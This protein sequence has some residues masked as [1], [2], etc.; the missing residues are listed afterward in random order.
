[1]FS[2]LY[3][4]RLSIRRTQHGCGQFLRL[5]LVGALLIGLAFGLI[6]GKRLFNYQVPL[7]F[8]ATGELSQGGNIWRHDPIIHSASERFTQVDLYPTLSR[9]SNLREDGSFN[10]T[11]LDWPDGFDVRSIPPANY[12]LGIWLTKLLLIATSSPGLI[13]NVLFIF[14]VISLYLLSLA[15]MMRLRFRS[16]YAVVGS[17]AIALNPSLFGKEPFINNYWHGILL[18]I[19]AIFLMFQNKTVSVRL[20]AI[21]GAITSVSGLY[22]SVMSP[23]LLVLAIIFLPRSI[24]TPKVR[25]LAIVVYLTPILIAMVVALGPTAIYWRQIG[26]TTVS[27]AQASVESWPARITDAL[28]VPNYSIFGNFLTRSSFVEANYGEGV[29]AYGPYGFLALLVGLYFSVGL[30]LKDRKNKAESEPMAAPASFLATLHFVPLTGGLYALFTP[31]MPDIIKSWE[32]FQV[33][34]A[35]VSVFFLGIWYN[36]YVSHLTRINRWIFQVVAVGSLLFGVIASLPIGKFGDPNGARNRW[37]SDHDFYTRIE[38]VSTNQNIL[39]L[40]VMSGFEGGPWGVIP[41]YSDLIGSI[42]TSK[43]RFSG[44]L[45]PRNAELANQNFNMKSDFNQV[46]REMREEGFNALVIDNRESNL[47]FRRNIVVSGLCEQFFLSENSQFSY[48]YL[49]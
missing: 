32:R 24:S 27:R 15:L 4:S 30:F 29:Y 10:S 46:V 34:L 14:A 17:L 44:G 18:T 43:V 8:S 35:I 2:P 40:P 39:I 7:G 49:P 1:V 37:A 3:R 6:Y 48:C 36:T 42:H 9:I 22:A 16:V 12:Y 33:P 5:G 20:L 25:V 45:V 28:S 47:S 21:A 23:I 38:S 11:R 19:G 26:Y 41:P 31:F 13:S